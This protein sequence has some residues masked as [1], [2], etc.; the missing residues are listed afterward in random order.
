[1]RCNSLLFTSTHKLAERQSD[2]SSISRRCKEI[3]F[4]E[5]RIRPY[6]HRIN[7]NA[8]S[9]E[10]RGSAVGRHC[11]RFLAAT[12]LSWGAANERR[13]M[14]LLRPVH[15]Y[16]REFKSV[17]RLRLTMLSRSFSIYVLYA[18]VAVSRIPFC[19]GTLA[20]S[21]RVHFGWR[22]LHGTKSV[23]HAVFMFHPRRTYFAFYV[24]VLRCL[25]V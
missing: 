18:H 10:P 12:E 23:P 2:S 1:L 17:R 4:R 13:F 15:S 9:G 22:S 7:H 11:S 25:H 19:K 5:Q 6:N 16:R 20:L 8:N 21:P 3:R 14:D 24:H